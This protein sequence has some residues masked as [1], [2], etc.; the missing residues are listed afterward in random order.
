MITA[1]IF[2]MDGLMIDSETVSRLAFDQAIK[3]FGGDGLSEEENIKYIGI[4][5]LDGAEDIIKTKKLKISKEELIDRKQKYYTQSLKEKIIVRPGLMDL[6]KDLKNKGIKMAI[7]S[8]SQRQSIEIVI[9]K[10]DIKKYVDF[11]CSGRDV[12]RGKPFPDVFLKAAAGLGVDPKDCLVLEDAPKGVEAGKSAG[13]IVFAIPS[14]E[15]KGGDFSKADLILSS[16]SI[17][18]NNLA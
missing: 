16:L 9:D 5:D 6:F 7:A 17:V 1:V 18:S 13:M 15:T 10:L 2:D 4:T 8:S 12:K 11:Y 14:R 3:D